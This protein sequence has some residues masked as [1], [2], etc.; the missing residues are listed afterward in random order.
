MTIAHLLNHIRQG[1]LLMDP[2]PWS[3]Y[4]RAHPIHAYIFRITVKDLIIL[5]KQGPLKTCPYDFD[6]P[7][8]VVQQIL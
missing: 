3:R 4:R 8:S 2:H 6:L 7:L 1:K 5:F